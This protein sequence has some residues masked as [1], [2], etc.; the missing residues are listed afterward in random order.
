MLLVIILKQPFVD[1]PGPPKN[2]HHT[3]VDKTEVWLQ[4]EW[5]ERT[6]GSEVTGFIVEHQ[7]DGK[8]DWVPFKTVSDAKSHVTGLE[9][10]KTYRFRV[11]AK[12][13]IGISQPDTSVPVT[14]QEKLG[15]IQHTKTI[16]T[17]MLS[18]SVMC[19]KAQFV[20]VTYF[21]NLV[22]HLTMLCLCLT[23]FSATCN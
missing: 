13:A 17:I 9:E 15:K 8:T 16:Y 23:F 14:C 1:P 3:D 10:G 4:W 21:S 11:M 19:H 7:E 20:F 2:L 12:N 6:G 5:P 18:I 22:S